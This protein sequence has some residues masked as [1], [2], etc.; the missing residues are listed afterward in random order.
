MTTRFFCAGAV[1]EFVCAVALPTKAI[2]MQ[3]SVLSNRI[4]WNGVSVAL[5]LN[6]I[7]IELLKYGTKVLRR[8]HPKQHAR[9]VRS[10]ECCA[11]V[12]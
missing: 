8:G 10:P 5:V 7:T 6:T 4:T 11:K 2:K 12:V 3:R 9:R 1:V